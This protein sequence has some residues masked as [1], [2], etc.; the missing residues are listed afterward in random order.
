MTSIKGENVNALKFNLILT[1][2]MTKILHSKLEE[3]I[4]KR[5]KN[6]VQNFLKTSYDKYDQFDM[7]KQDCLKGFMKILNPRIS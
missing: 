6:S 7:R 4:Q 2:V 5:T 3:E 1:N